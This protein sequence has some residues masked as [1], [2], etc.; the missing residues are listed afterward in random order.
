M[1][2][3]A[4]ADCDLAFLALPHGASC[5][6]GPRPGADGASR[7][8]ISA[9]TTGST[10]LPAT[11]RRTEPPHPH[12]DELGSGSTACPSCSATRSAVRDKV[13][14]PGCYPTSAILALAPLLRRRADRTQRAHGQCGVGRQ[15]RW[16]G[17]Q[18]EPHVRCRRRRR[19]CVWRADPPSPA[20]D[21][22]GARHGL[23]RR[24]DRGLHAASRADATRH[25]LH[26][27]RP[28]PCRSNGGLDGCCAR[29]RLCLGAFRRRDRPPATDPLGGRVEP[30]L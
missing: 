25:P 15:R 30:V 22:A 10:P 7:S 23:G 5:G 29:G 26:V 13:A 16:E 27:L 17:R 11:R 20:R 4:A 18:A 6:P 21:R 24:A 19:R 12:P 9:P 14:A 28:C 3:E 8:S 2:P 1:D